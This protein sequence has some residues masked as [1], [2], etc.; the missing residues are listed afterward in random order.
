MSD[1]IFIAALIAFF[2]ICALYVQLCDRIMGP[3]DLADGGNDNST[4]VDS[5]SPIMVAT[6]VGTSAGVNA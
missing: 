3:D 6:P 5:G 2:V 1:V 4:A